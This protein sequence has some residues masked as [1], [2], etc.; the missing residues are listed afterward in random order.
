MAIDL[1]GRNVLVV[2]DEA[3][4]SLMLED[5]LTE[6]GVKVVG[7]APSIERALVLAREAAL[8]A[9]ILDVNVRGERIEPVAAILR[10]RSIPLVFAT[11]YGRHA[12]AMAEGEP[13]IDKP[14]TVERVEESLRACLARRKAG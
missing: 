12:G 11:G 1:A 10:G 2:E 14:Y 8:D 5:I 3:L 9:A 4:V 7:P 6:L 13:V